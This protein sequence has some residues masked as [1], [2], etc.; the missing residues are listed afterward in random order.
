MSWLVVRRRT[1]REVAATALVVAGLTGFV[2]LVYVVVVLGIG[3]L[4][5][6]TDPPDLVLSVV[7][8]AVVAVAF[9]RVQDVV[10]RAARRIAYAGAPPPSEVWQRFSSAVTGSYPTE[11]L[12]ARMARV[13]AEGTGARSAEVWL[14]VQDRRVLA[15]TWPPGTSYPSLGQSP[16]HRHQLP[17]RL[18]DEVLGD[19]VVTTPAQLTSVEQRLFEGFA[20]QAG[21]AL[22]SVRLRAELA[23]RIE[24]LSRRAEELRASRRR[25]VEVQDERRRVLERDIHDGAQQHLV[26][27]AVNL[28]LAQTLGARSPARAAALLEEQRAATA[29]AIDTLVQLAR[30]VYPPPLADG[31]LVP[32]LRAVASTSPIPVTVVGHGSG[33][34]DPATESAAYFSC[35]E[36]LQNAAKHS[37]ATAIRVEVESGAD[38]LRVSIEDDGRGFDPAVHPTGAGLTNLRDRIE[39]LGGAVTTESVPGRGTRI[40]AVLPAKPALLAE[41]AR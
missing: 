18:G 4:I 20:D 29:A 8:T 37:G 31:G 15:A 3:A 5:G 12:P 33:R 38:A 30:G 21:L 34:Y 27:L 28:R 32:A 39:T 16:G 36:A 2:L 35:L 41:G 13:L 14:T 24:E 19:L 11:E 26:A 23:A 22:H 7:A 17:V 9:D 10:E 40:V 1:R 25:L 6:R